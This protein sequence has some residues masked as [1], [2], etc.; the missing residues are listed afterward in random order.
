MREGNIAGV[1]ENFC[2]DGFG[3]IAVTAGG[4]YESLES[5][6]SRTKKSLNQCDSND[7]QYD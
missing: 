1:N 2:A 4:C 5:K 6:S 3:L 7:G